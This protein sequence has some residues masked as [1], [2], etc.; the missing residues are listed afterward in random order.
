MTNP[1][2]LKNTIESL[3]VRDST[4]TYTRTGIGG[5][6]KEKLIE[7]QLTQSQKLASLG[8]LLSS[9]A[10]ETCNLNNCITFNTPILK[11]YLKEL[12][13]VI[14]NYIVKHE[15]FELLGIPYPEFRKDIFN[16][17]DNIEHAANRITETSSGLKDFVRMNT[18]EKQAWVEVKEVTRKAV[19]ICRGEIRKTVRSLEVNIA[20][21]IPS[22]FIDPA[23]LEQILVN[24][25]INAA[26][27]AD[28]KDSWLMITARQANSQRSHLI[29]EVSDNGCGVDEKIRGKIFEPF[30]TTKEEIKGRGL[31]L[32][33]SK[34]LIE[35]LNGHISVES[36]AGNRLI[37]ARQANSQ[38]SHLI[39]EVSDNGCGMDEKI[40]GKIFEPFFTTKEEI[41]GRGLGLFVSKN[42]IEK[43]DGH[44][45]VESIAG[46]G[47]TFRLD[48]CR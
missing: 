9:I 8:L 19:L 46:R 1:N 10:H 6:T 33:V 11:E 32:F 44:I 39:I 30:F 23:A 36:I 21:D 37:T 47:T 24:L 13:S 29:I 34:N 4:K 31:G 35:K 17:L 48:L 15:D 42:L 43:L 28:K 27:A 16:I 18:S 22:I 5:V 12:V 14:D 41:K 38:R 7:K 2:R 25:L 3:P 26:Q 45:S 20:E 40:R